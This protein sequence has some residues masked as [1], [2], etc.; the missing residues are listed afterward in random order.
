M[1]LRYGGEGVSSEVGAGVEGL[2]I[3]S[4]SRRRGVKHGVEGVRLKLCGAFNH[5]IR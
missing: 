2:I 1:P 4:T 3:I 5:A